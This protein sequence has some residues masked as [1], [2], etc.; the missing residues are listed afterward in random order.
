MKAW[1]LS[2]VG[3][4]FIGV[5]LDVILPDGK[6]NNF[7]KHIFSIFILFVIISPLGN[8]VIKGNWFNTGQEVVDTN[9]IYENNL[10]KVNALEKDIAANL[11]TC[12]ISNCSVIISADIFSESLQI[13]QVYVDITNAKYSDVSNVKDKIV[14]V[15]TKLINVS[16]NEVIIYG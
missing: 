16:N 2:L 11:E 7:I 15:V 13:N 4:V 10:N 1:V 6:T 3:I 12:G 5:L 9:F 8:L 14:A